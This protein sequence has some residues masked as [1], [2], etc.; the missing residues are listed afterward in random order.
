MPNNKSKSVE[1][2]ELR[3]MFG[4]SPTLLNTNSY[5]FNPITQTS[6]PD[7]APLQ[8][9]RGHSNPNDAC[10]SSSTSDLECFQNSNKKKVFNKNN[11]EPPSLYRHRNKE[12]PDYIRS[13]ENLDRTRIARMHNEGTT[14]SSAS[15]K[16]CHYSL[17]MPICLFFLFVVKF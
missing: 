11:S 4:S 8:Y 3:T 14:S 13:Y 2:N 6:R 9:R 1:L 5:N 7:A 17:S 10:P 16:I 15:T 12:H